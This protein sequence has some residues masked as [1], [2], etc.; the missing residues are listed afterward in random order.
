MPT[1]KSVFDP[2][3][4]GLGRKRVYDSRD[5]QFPIRA[6]LPRKIPSITTKYWSDTGV[7]L[8]QGTSS[9]CVGHSLAHYLMDGPV[10]NRSITLDPYYIYRE[11]QKI[12]EWPYEEP[13]YGGTSVRAGAAV[14]LREGFI[15]SYHWATELQ[16]LIDTVLTIGPVVVGTTWYEAMFY[17]DHK[18]IVRVGG[19][20]AGGHA[21][22]INGV[23]T[24]KKLFRA[25]NSWGRAFG[26]KGR[27]YISFDDMGMLIEDYGE[28]CLMQEVKKGA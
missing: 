12:D 2:E 17:P 20:A 21:W 1:P 23:N 11:A 6:L 25:K 5:E 9:A 7:F 19:S 10:K 14:L 13:V 26:K 15:S 22:I 8:D 24:K 3:N 16:T 18:G 4:V 27:F 28:I